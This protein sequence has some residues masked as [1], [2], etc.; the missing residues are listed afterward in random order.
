MAHLH[1]TRELLD[2]LFDGERSPED[3]VPLVLAHLFDLCPYCESEFKAWEEQATRDP[4]GSYDDIFARL[5][6]GAGTVEA[7][8][9]AEREEAA[10]TLE[11]ILSLPRHERLEAIKA[12]PRRFQGPALAEL[13]IDESRQQMP[14]RPQDALALAQL[15]KAVLLHAPLSGFVQ[16]LYARAMVHVAN[17]LRVFGKLAEAGEMFDDARFLLRGEGGSDVRLA[18]EFDNLEG[19][20]RK[21]QRRFAEAEALFKRAALG[22]EM[23]RSPV[24]AA[25]ISINLSLLYRDTGELGSGEEAALRA[26]SL[27]DS[28]AEPRLCLFARHNLA[29]CL[30]ESDRYLEAREVA[31]ENAPHFADHADPLSRLRFTWLE[32][33]IAR[34]LGETAGAESALLAVQKGFARA[35]LAYDAAL[36]SLDLAVLYLS[37]GR[38]AEVKNLAR[39]MVGVFE[40]KEIHREAL[41]AVVLFR[42]AAELERVSRQLVRELARYL[43]QVQADPGLPFRLPA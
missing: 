24:E 16:E 43:S 34:G 41:T 25:R 9:T 42:D 7:K 30:C 32:G 38:T 6:S 31:T 8:V 26:L 28:E 3:L 1:L 12:S 2:A 14:G 20:L 5:R 11:E 18:A 19:L 4:A 23:E 17:S 39:A 33:L 40:E 10:R 21:A 22:Y 36:V 29:L 37:Q 15:A 35:G 13:L 27:L